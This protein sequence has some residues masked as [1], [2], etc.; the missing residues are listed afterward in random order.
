MKGE[1]DLH[2]V[3]KRQL[4]RVGVR[5]P[6]TP[7]SAESWADLLTRISRTY[8]GNE[9]DR[10]LLERS[11]D[12]SS[13]EMQELYEQ[14]RRASESRIGAERDRLASVLNALGDGL[15]VL[16][17]DG[18]VVS[19][20]PAAA[21][22]LG[23]AEDELT[24]E[25]ALAF[26][27]LRPDI[28]DADAER[29]ATLSIDALLKPLIPD[30]ELDEDDG[31]DD[32]GD[33]AQHRED[34]ARPLAA[35]LAGRSVHFDR[36]LLRRGEN[37][38]VPV[39]CTLD[40]LIQR[41]EVTGCVFLFRDM[42]NERAF[43]SRL[44][45]LTLRLREARDAA[46]DANRTKSAFLAKMSHELRTPLNAI[47]GY[48]DLIAEE[49]DDYDLSLLKEDITRIQDAGE[50]LLNLINDI[51][52]ISKIEAGKMV[53]YR[54]RFP[55]ED[56]LRSV[57]STIRPLMTKSE[58]ELVIDCAPEVG[59]MYTDRTKL[60]QALLNLLS[61]AA[62][63]T[64]R[65]RCTLRVRGARVRDAS[66]IL[67]EVADTG[68]GIRPEKIA[69]LFDAF[70]QAEASTTR[71]FGG[72]GLGL[73]ITRHFCTMLGGDIEVRSEYGEGSTFIIKLPVGELAADGDAPTATPPRVADEH[74]G[75]PDILLVIDDD[76]Q[77]FDM[78]QRA[79]EK[80]DFTVAYAHN[81]EEGV[82]LAR[83]LQPSVIT[84]DVQFPGIDGW[85]ILSE[86]KSDP[87]IADIPV[88]MLSVVSDQQRA[89]TLGAAEY[90]VKPIEPRRLSELLRRYRRVGGDERGG[91]GR[92][93]T[94]LVADDDPETR[95]MLRR[96]LER[97][98]WQPILAVDGQAALDELAHRRPALVLLDMMMPRKDGFAVIEA[99]RASP[100]LRAIPIV[101]LT[102]MELSLEEREFLAMQTARVMTK[103][104]Q[105]IDIVIDE[106]G[107]ALAR[108][109]L[110][111]TP[112]PRPAPQLG[113]SAHD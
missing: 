48:S 25:R 99:M 110:D 97:D 49:A 73:A 8:A 58:N 71:D 22:L 14:L 12:I 44:H 54:E 102:A 70:T 27:L 30:D 62:K 59:E 94:V 40:P 7:P 2:R 72:T 24:G 67:F 85:G 4:R 42:T 74:E 92:A 18:R 100:E 57:V 13:H 26:F 111:A 113:A 107:R 103:G 31:E 52:D 104:A 38:L 32:A 39:S 79:M 37:L 88:V 19:L 96:A 17:R 77:V 68:V 86:I 89:F 112:A 20:N 78:V 29:S 23:R 106:L 1:S 105:P 109:S 3:L 95:E 84:L 81:G 90:L 98:G 53:V 101:V 65:G 66:W 87:Q 6:A 11:L 76:P 56:V 83:V 91:S 50:H 63:F 15:C 82:H 108:R 5:D 21:A 46:L 55:V 43:E 69:T 33:E 41:G 10:Y 47:I 93:D 60:R 61:N 80:H 64:R 45:N 34:Q 35:V 75:G 16:D 51:L 9:E 36:A 28:A